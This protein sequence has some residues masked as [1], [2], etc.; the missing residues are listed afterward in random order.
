MMD[1]DLAEHVASIFMAMTYYSY[2]TTSLALEL[3]IKHGLLETLSVSQTRSVW[4]G[5]KRSTAAALLLSPHSFPIWVLASS[6]RVC[7]RARTRIV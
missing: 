6:V 1:V 3:F 4:A 2:D 5:G 7:A